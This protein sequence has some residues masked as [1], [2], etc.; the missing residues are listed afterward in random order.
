MKMKL[1]V[2]PEIYHMVF[3]EEKKYNSTMQW[4]CI[5]QYIKMTNVI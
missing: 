1:R 3:R 5:Q 2:F 4:Y